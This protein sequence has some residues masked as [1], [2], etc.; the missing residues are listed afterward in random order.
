MGCGLPVG[1]QSGNGTCCDAMV[2]AGGGMSLPDGTTDGQGNAPQMPDGTQ[3]EVPGMPDGTTG[4]GQMGGQP[5][6]N[7]GGN[8][9]MNAQN[10]SS[11]GI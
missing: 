7:A 6:G 3:G 10:S 5:G 1:I 9:G 11:N 4:G 8:G 2:N